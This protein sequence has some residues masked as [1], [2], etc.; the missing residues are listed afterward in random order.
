MKICTIVLLLL[1]V[2]LGL[3]LQAQTKV[4]PTDTAAWLKRKPNTYA[5]LH[6]H[7]TL[8]NYYNK[9]HSFST[10]KN[11]DTANW[12]YLS[13]TNLLQKR[14]GK[15]SN[16]KNYFQ[17][18]YSELTSGTH[19]FSVVCNSI[20]PLEKVVSLKGKIGVAKSVS[21]LPRERLLELR[22]Y[23]GWEEF[24]GEYKFWS[25]QI[26][27]YKGKNIQPVRNSAELNYC[28]N[29]NITA[30]VANIEGGQ[31][32]YGPYNSENVKT[33]EGLNNWLQE[34]TDNIYLLR[35]DSATYPYKIFSMN[36]AHLSW[37]R[38]VGHAKSLDKR[39]KRRLLYTFSRLKGFRSTLFNKHAEGFLDTQVTN[40]FPCS[41]VNN[42]HS[43]STN[44]TATILDAMLNNTNG[45][46]RILP[47][48]KHMDI[49]A[50]SEY[51][52]YLATRKAN[53]DTKPLPII[54]SHAAVS[55]ENRQWALFTGQCP[56]YDR[57]G[58]ILKTRK[59]YLRLQKKFNC[60]AP[61][62]L[63]E[64]T[65][66]F[67]PWS[68]NLYDEEI[69][70][71]CQSG[72]IIGVILEQRAL[73]YEMKMFNSHKHFKDIKRFLTKNNYIRN[74]YSVEGYKSVEPLLRNM[75][76]MIDK[77]DTSLEVAW[78]LICLGSDFD[79]GIDP[80]NICPT[81]EQLPQLESALKRYL[82]LFAKH[83][84]VEYL[85]LINPTNGQYDLDRMMDLFF[86]E[87]LKNFLI[88]NF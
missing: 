69:K 26:Q 1:N 18:S 53:G 73:G 78:K 72:G 66:W 31:A 44:V 87:N 52:H 84:G 54:C 19:S 64:N 57:F 35:T 67:Y 43:Y 50:R 4:Y 21:K 77:A 10:Y 24:N 2:F 33:S 85:L 48:I 49:L 11:N 22:Y 38:L 46:R 25:A 5:D 74:G 34:I 6:M 36:L 63:P 62:I 83:E 7:N 55:G 3:N 79:G 15:D 28:V 23:T 12:E 47:D 20:T 71:I 76:Y 80:I 16:F 56:N 29:N 86:E 37:L 39:N 59:T 9:Y 32:L 30:V 75:L 17:C 88:K 68:I 60:S 8:K 70:T 27:A 51:Y 40:N 42:N 45:S 81:A 14:K 61:T 58:E 13:K 41:C 82:P 65:G